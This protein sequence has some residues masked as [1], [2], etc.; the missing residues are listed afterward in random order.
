[1][2]RKP[3]IVGVG[4]AEADGPRDEW[5]I[6]SERGCSVVTM[7]SNGL[8]AA[9]Q[10]DR[11]RFALRADAEMSSASAVHLHEEFPGIEFLIAQRLRGHRRRLSMLIHNP[12]S[13]RRRF[14]LGTL[15]LASAIDTILCL[16]PGAAA[17]IARDYRIDPVRVR[18]IWSR[19]DTVYFR[20]IAGRRPDDRLIVS[21]GAIN[22]DYDLLA[23]ATEGLGCDVKIAS[24]SAW[25]H[26]VTRQPGLAGRPPEHVEIHS[27]GDYSSLRELYAKSRMVV[28][29]LRSTRVLSG[30]TVALEAMAMGRPLI[31]TDSPLAHGYI[32]HGVT[33]L[34]VPT[35]DAGALRGAI[36]KLLDNPDRAESMG[37]QARATVVA[38]FSLESYAN[39]I[40]DAMN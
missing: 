4:P 9:S 17:V 16:S 15:R 19:V 25:T 3:M 33:G 10:R 36:E 5:S 35:G 22:R 37:R 31:M 32:E 30:V 27:W 38:R 24:D 34:L 12:V 29:P 1:M 13:L 28:V 26:S 39:R 6:F 20:P 14:P 8:D 7:N 18:V 2:T 21:A 23:V 11:L 40:L